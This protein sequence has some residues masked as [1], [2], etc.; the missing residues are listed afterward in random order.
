MKIKKNI[1]FIYTSFSSFV[2]TDYEILSKFSNVKKYK[3]ETHKSFIKMV[4][5]QIRLKIFLL[6]NI[7]KSDV[8]Y[9][10]F[11]DYHSFLPILFAKI[12]RKKSILILG[13]YDVTYIPE[14]E[15]GSF[16]K[17]IRGFLT[18]ISIKLAS[19]VLAVSNY[20]K[21]EIM[22]RVTDIQ[23][24][25]LY[26]SLSTKKFLLKDFKR[27]YILSI[28]GVEMEKQFKL[29]GVDLFIELAKNLPNEEFL[30][31]GISKSIIKQI[32]YIPNNLEILNFL[33]QKELIDYY[34]KSKIYCQL[35]MIESFGLSVAESM[36]CGCI[37][38]TF[39]V[40]ALREVI[41]SSGYL[42]KNGDLESV[43]TAITNI[44]YSQI[45]GSFC[46]ERILKKFPPRNREKGLNKIFEEFYNE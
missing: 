11:A 41:G 2:K 21:N 7:W 34:N 22:K 35:S 32:K 33:P 30:L 14:I 8:I 26:L 31:I 38:V 4:L 19:K 39:D 46:R 20:T 37:P 43:K 25:V 5:E 44:E 18:K 1:L 15:Y 40:G 27:E 23:V 36:L 12:F 42:I 16:N 3:F 17:P 6:F 29:K 45:E 9:C 10:W 13:G 24:E 28:S